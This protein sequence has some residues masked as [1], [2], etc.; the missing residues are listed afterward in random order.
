MRSQAGAWERGQ[1]GNEELKQSISTSQ[2][3]CRISCDASSLRRRR[4]RVTESHRHCVNWER[5]R[6]CP[7]T[8]PLNCRTEW[9]GEAPAEPHAEQAGPVRSTGSRES[10]PAGERV[11]TSVAESS[12]RG[13]AGASPSRKSMPSVSGETLSLEKRNAAFSAQR[14][15][16]EPPPFPCFRGSGFP[17][18]VA[19]RSRWETRGPLPSTVPSHQQ[20]RPIQ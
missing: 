20:T 19:T 10:A 14:T 1:F 5:L 8:R 11:D 13:S 18:L 17:A 4:I 6:V 15:R 9:E 16:S 7:E 12:R 3:G 2:F